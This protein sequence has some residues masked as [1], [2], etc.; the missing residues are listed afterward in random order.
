MKSYGNPGPVC[1]I[2][3]PWAILLC[4][5]SAPSRA[6]PD[7]GACGQAGPSG[8]GPGLTATVDNTQAI[9]TYFLMICMVAADCGLRTSLKLIGIWTRPAYCGL[10]IISPDHKSILKNQ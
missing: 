5:G 8:L 4:V 9:K 3:I 1:D 2:Q 7:G 10:L 6:P